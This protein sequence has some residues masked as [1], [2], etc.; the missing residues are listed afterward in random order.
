MNSVPGKEQA[1]II[2]HKA[3]HKSGVW[4]LVLHNDTPEI[5]EI[6]TDRREPAESARLLQIEDR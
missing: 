5:P 1:V 6:L 4:K 2:P 3:Q